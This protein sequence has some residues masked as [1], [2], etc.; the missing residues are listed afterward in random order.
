LRQS[1]SL[2]GGGGLRLIVCVQL[3]NQI[4]KKKGCC[5]MTRAA[6]IDLV[7]NA[8]NKDRFYKALQEELSNRFDMEELAEAFVDRFE[9]EFCDLAVEGLAKELAEAV[10]PF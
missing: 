8:I 2:A 7:T 5:K 10:L 4:Q 1:T 3:E 6:L 9:E